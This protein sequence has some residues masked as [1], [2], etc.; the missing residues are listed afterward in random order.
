MDTKKPKRIYKPR[1]KKNKKIIQDEDQQ[2][3]TSEKNNDNSNIITKLK[4][5][6]HNIY[7][8]PLED[9]SISGY[10]ACFY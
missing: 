10:I 3:I 6:E 7:M 4:T 5:I 8:C 1:M 2:S 9:L